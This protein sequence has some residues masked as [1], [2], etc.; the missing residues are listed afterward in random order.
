MPPT[1]V[2]GP[3]LAGQSY[4]HRK[5]V[6]FHPAMQVQLVIAVLATRD[7]EPAGQAR[8][9]ELPVKFLYVPPKQFVHATPSLGAVHPA[10]HLQSVIRVLPFIELLFPGHW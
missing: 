1:V 9:A 3:E 10:L 6:P 4:V 7:E 2:D 8:Q 5:P